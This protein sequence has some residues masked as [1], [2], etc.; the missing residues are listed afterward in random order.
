MSKSGTAQ[1]IELFQQGNKQVVWSREITPAQEKIIYD[2]KPLQPG[3]LYQWHMYVNVPFPKK[4]V[5]MQF[6]V[7]ETQ[8]RARITSELTQLETQL[9]KQGANAEKIA[10][11]KA[12]YFAQQEL[13]SDTLREIYTVPNPSAELTKIIQQISSVDYCEATAK[14]FSFNTIRLG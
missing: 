11:E 4:S 9:Q 10:L 7:I 3:E 13:W 8:K 5:S 12:N 14:T 2:G 1:K 6:Q